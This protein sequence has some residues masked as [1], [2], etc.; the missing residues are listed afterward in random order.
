MRR[1]PSSARRFAGVGGREGCR[2][3]FD[4]HEMCTAMKAQGIEVHD[5]TNAPERQSLVVPMAADILA[6]MR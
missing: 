6:A 1:F 5:A 3:I 4:P 2:I